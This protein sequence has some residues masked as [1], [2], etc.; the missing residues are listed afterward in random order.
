MR[1]QSNPAVWQATRTSS[2]AQ[3]STPASARCASAI[4]LFLRETCAAITHCSRSCLSLSSKAADWPFSRWPKRPPTRRLRLAG[5]GPFS[6]IAAS[7]L[8]SSTSA[9]T[10]PSI[11]SICGVVHPTSV[12]TPSVRLPSPNTNCTGSRASCGTGNGWISSPSTAKA[13]WL[14]ITRTATPSRSCAIASVPAVSHTGSLCLRASRPTPPIWSL[15]SCVTTM[16]ARSPGCKPSRASRATLSASPKPQS[17]STRVA[18]ASTSRPLP[19]LPLPRLANRITPAPASLQ[20]FVQQIDDAIP[21]LVVGRLAVGASDADPALLARLADHDLQLRRGLR[22]LAAPEGE[23]GEDAFVTLAGVV[24]VGIDVAHK[25]DTLGAVTVFHREADTVERESDPAPGAV[26]AFIHLQH[27]DAGFLDDARLLRLL[28]LGQQ[29]IG[30]ALFDAEAQH[31]AAQHFGFELG[32]GLAR[33]P[34]GDVLALGGIDLLHTAVA[35]VDLGA[36][37]A[38]FDPRAELVA[39]GGGIGAVDQPAD[40]AA[41]HVLRN[42]GAVFCPV[43]LHQAGF[44]RFQ[45]DDEAVLLQKIFE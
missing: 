25:I 34:L 37:L 23:I 30:A 38:R 36:V 18:F 2:S 10:P 42:V 44:R 31:Q 24:D 35:D 5:Y 20:F 11:A 19:S 21:R 43:G 9:S 13:A 17:I 40:A 8:H 6:S 4:V 1:I 29:C 16:P 12:S 33:L 45:I 22:R 7:W 32:V 14:S 28:L 26:E 15:C 41:D 39:L 27:R 3:S